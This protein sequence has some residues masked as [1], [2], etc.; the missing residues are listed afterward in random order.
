ML[1][2]RVE[3]NRHYQR[4]PLASSGCPAVDSE[5]SLFAVSDMVDGSTNMFAMDS[6]DGEEQQLP[7]TTLLLMSADYQ[8]R[9]QKAAKVLVGAVMR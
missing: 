7:Y 6:K 1:L 9:L 2:H 8:G 5:Y 3:A 4:A